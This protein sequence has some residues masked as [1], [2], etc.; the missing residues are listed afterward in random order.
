MSALFLLALLTTILGP[1]D[2]AAGEVVEGELGFQL[3]E[4]LTRLEGLGF[5]GIVGVEY[6]GEPILIRGYGMADRERGLPV[7]PET[8]FDIGSITKQ[9]TAA[10]ILALQD[11][12]KLSVQDP[13]AK[14]LENLPED[15]RG[16]TLHHL[17]THTSGLAEPAAGDYDLRAT[18]AWVREQAFRAPLEWK[19]GARY[20]YR[21]VN[22][23][24][25][26]MVIERV[27]GEPYEAFLR[28]RLFEPVGMHSTGY[29]L[30][31]FAPEAF[32]I[33]YREG[34]L[35]GTTLGH[36]LL[37]DGPCWTLRANGGIESTVGDMLRWHHAL[38]GD[39]VLSHAAHELLETPFA[40][41][42][43]GSS[44][45]Y[46]WSIETTPRG[47][48][49][50]THSG[51]NGVFYADFLRFV[52]EG[53]CIFLATNVGSRMRQSLAS[54]LAAI[55][56]GS[57]ARAVPETIARDRVFLE[58]Y[59]GVYPLDEGDGAEALQLENLG[60]RLALVGR[61]AAAEELLLD[62][63]TRARTE[64]VRAIA[65]AW[66][67]G[68]DKP[69][70]DAYRGRQ[71][72]ASIRAELAEGRAHWKERLGAF[73]T[74]GAVAARSGV[75]PRIAIEALFER[76]SGW[77]TTTWST[78][79]AMIGFRCLDEPPFSGIARIELFPFSPRQ[80]RSYEDRTGPGIAVSFDLD[81]AGR[82]RSMTLGD[83]AIELARK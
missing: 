58:R 52:D 78:A 42:G 26:G 82:A 54:D 77:L 48:K 15:K 13:L 49:L 29:L 31:R 66:S 7:L 56:H 19:P 76:G 39:R 47:T 70:I 62:P 44:Y 18:A 36:E 28:R 73:R 32:A 27:S 74:L 57:P 21:N 45:G 38:Q 17:L 22:F 25:L 9:F 23:S 14:Y 69:L 35:W 30:P 8:V 75:E 24:L 67:A 63:R 40:D 11:D 79:G 55:L 64:Q 5:S 1:D 2:L 50:V 60:D 80:F 59:A 83:P 43:G 81:E 37:A 10:A 71:T 16:I 72:P 3:D 34:E 33:G 68:D 61:G 41:E 46:G 53:H 51:S 12:G 65:A 6:E 4:F 20:G